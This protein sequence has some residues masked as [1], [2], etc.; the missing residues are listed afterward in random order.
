MLNISL[1]GLFVSLESNFLSSLHILDISPLSDV[2]LVKMFYQSIGCLFVLQ[3]VFFA[4]Q[5]LCNFMRSHL[6]KKI[7][8]VPMCSR[9]FPA[10]FSISFS[11]SGFMWRYLIHLD[12]S[13]VQG[14]KNRWICILLHDNR[15]L[16]QQHLF[17]ML[18]FST[19]SF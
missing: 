6:S 13:F 7:S 4:L 8:P 18:F 19:G 2:G 12:L 3:T 14:D 5:K 15:Q 16:N 1:I 11:V 9:L 10:F 17:T